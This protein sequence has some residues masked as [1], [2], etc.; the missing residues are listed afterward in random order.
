MMI[1][2]TIFVYQI[3]NLLPL[4]TNAQTRNAVKTAMTTVAEREGWLLSDM[5]V[6]SVTA[7][8]IRLTHRQHLRG[9]DPKTCVRIT[10][11][12]SSLHSCD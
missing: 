11:S 9:T 10:L 5:L 8:K 6:T 7:D 1:L 3:W 2:G 4:Y 12:D